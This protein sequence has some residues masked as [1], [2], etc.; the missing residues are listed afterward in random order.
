ME[1]PNARLTDLLSQASVQLYERNWPELHQMFEQMY[2]LAADEER[3]KQRDGQAILAAETAV[4]DGQWQWGRQLYQ[5]VLHHVSEHR[6]ASNGLREIKELERVDEEMRRLIEAGDSAFT[7]GDYNQAI[8]RYKDAKNQTEKARILKYHASLEQKINQALELRNWRERAQETIASARRLQKGGEL[9]QALAE[10]QRLQAQLPE[11]H[12]YTAM[13]EEINALVNQ[14]KQEANADQVL[15]EA[16]KRYR[17]Q[18][19]EGALELVDTPALADNEESKRL[20]QRCRDQLDRFIYPSL[21]RAEQAQNRGNWPDAFA[22]LQALRKEYPLNPN[23]KRLW[24]RVGRKAGEQALDLGRQANSDRNFQEAAAAF[25]RAGQ[26]FERVLEVYPDHDAIPALR[27]EAVDLAYIADNAHQAWKLWRDKGERKAA[28][29]HL[30]NASGRIGSAREQG[31]D[32]AAVNSVVEAMARE[33][34]GELESIAEDE[35]RLENGERQLG[36]RRFDSAAESFRQ[37]LNAKWPEH[38]QQA[39]GGL[40]RAEA[41]IRGFQAAIDRAKASADPE[42]RVRHLEDAYGLWPTG[43]HA[44][45]LLTTACLDA[46]ESALKDGR[47]QDAAAFA[48]RALELDPKNR[49]ADTIRDR[50]DNEPKILADLTRAR[51]ELALLRDGAEASAERYAALASQLQETAGRARPYPDLKKQADALLKEVRA[52]QARWQQLESHLDQATQNMRAGR[53]QE[54]VDLLAKGVKALGDEAPEMLAARLQAWQRALQQQTEVEAELVNLWRQADQSYQ[55]GP[56]SGDFTA[57]LRTLTQIEA[58]LS[59]VQNTANAIEAAACLLA[60]WKR[61]SSPKICAS[62]L[63]SRATQPRIV[64]RPRGC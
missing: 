12:I 29:T 25:K 3:Q 55:A 15:D 35:R 16:K 20:K 19:F 42:V 53:W 64:R 62:G 13:A 6:G 33:I 41:A 57:T 59:A 54:G 8:D 46:A 23:W 51:S 38:R 36:N 1:D 31:R 58:H 39:R 27:D 44:V 30:D 17:E 49:T 56:E 5:L 22:E 11:E 24:L 45:E 9:L 2:L 10:L 50:I 52:E 40:D 21:D 47:S 34:Q 4:Q 14:I 18:D 60:W 37:A 32:Y 28:L 61:R 43:S 48:N 7:A 26:A 63:R